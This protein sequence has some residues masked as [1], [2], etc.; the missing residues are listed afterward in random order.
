MKIALIGNMNNNNFAMLRYFRHL[1]VD[2]HLFL[3]EE[4]GRFKSSHFGYAADTYYPEIYEQHIT[5]TILRNHQSDV[6]GANILFRWAFYA[7]FIASKIAQKPHSIVYKPPRFG[8]KQMIK[9]TFSG[10][11]TLIGSGYSPAILDRAS[12][13]LTLFFPYSTGVEGVGSVDERVG[14]GRIKVVHWLTYPFYILARKKQIAALKKARVLISPDGEASMNVF[15]NDVG[16][17]AKILSLPTFYNLEDVPEQV[18][19][20][21]EAVRAR[22][23]KHS[24]SFVFHS[25][26]LWQRTSG[27]SDR[28]YSQTSKNNHWAFE[29]F[30]DLI[31]QRG[32][33]NPLLITFD[34]G[35][36]AAASKQLCADL[37]IE[38]HVLWLPTMARKDIAIIL[39][40]CD[41]GI[42]EFYSEKIIWGGTGW[43][44]LAAGKPLIQGFQF[45]DGE[46]ERD[47]EQ[48]VPPLLPVRAKED[49]LKHITQIAD[50][51]DEA[52]KMG[53]AAR[54]WFDTH[55]GLGLAKKWLQILKDATRASD[56]V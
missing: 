44:V 39:S 2:A 33:T 28:A 55:N 22:I 10:Y 7:M 16:R 38:D 6:L 42:G 36:D 21:L 34:Y 30:A 53:A 5:R 40:W 50:A 12:V 4:D 11:D 54:V 26:H 48:P 9:D 46:F 29:A 35:K 8:A 19:P 24:V 41:A 14:A 56:A 43:E 45:E 1:G 18:T 15:K 3:Y 23:E 13:A 25:R 31:K 20:E 52:R 32:D 51:P 17:S 47:F 49:I 37:G 27:M